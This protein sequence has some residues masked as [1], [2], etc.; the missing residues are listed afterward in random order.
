[1][2]VEISPASLSGEVLPEEEFSVLGFVPIDVIGLTKNVLFRMLNS[3][4]IESVEQFLSE[5]KQDSW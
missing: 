1:M 3:E 2:Q 5:L 4:Q